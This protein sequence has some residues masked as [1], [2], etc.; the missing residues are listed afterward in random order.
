MGQKYAS[1][2]KNFVESLQPKVKVMKNYHYG[3]F[4]QKDG[5]F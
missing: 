3:P 1:L 5:F 4:S 2:D